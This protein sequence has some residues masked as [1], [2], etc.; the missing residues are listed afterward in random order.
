[1]TTFNSPDYVAAWLNGKQIEYLS[2]ENRWVK[3]DLTTNPL[4]APRFKYRMARP[5]HADFSPP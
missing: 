4:K 5:K 1:M 3:A 2:V